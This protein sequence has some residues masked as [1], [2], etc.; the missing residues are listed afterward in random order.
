M[1]I[2]QHESVL[3]ARVLVHFERQEYSEMYSILENHQFSHSSH[4]RLQQLWWEARYREAQRMR[5]RLV[6]LEYINPTVS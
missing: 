5:G 2:S 3:R 1:A 6:V 4:L